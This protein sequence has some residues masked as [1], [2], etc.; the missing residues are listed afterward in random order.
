M[1]LN[2]LL[3]LFQSLDLCLLFG[4]CGVPIS[5]ASTLYLALV[6]DGITETE[7]SRAVDII[8]LRAH[9]WPCTWRHSGQHWLTLSR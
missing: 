8:M 6:V 2:I 1:Q 7:R 9:S 4:I 3:W 5:M